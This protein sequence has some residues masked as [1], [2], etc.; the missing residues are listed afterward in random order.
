M[1]LEDRIEQLRQMREAEP[2]AAV[3]AALRKALKDRSNLIVTEAAKAVG[4]LRR[5]AL[6]E[7]LLSAFDRLFENPVKTDPKCWGKTAIVK[8]LTS[9]DYSESPPFLRGARHVQMEPV[10]GGQEDAAMHLRANSV[11]ALVACTDLTRPE[12]LRHLV[13]AL[14][15][16]LDTVRVEAV[17]ALQQ[18]NGEESCLALRVKAHAGDRRPVVLGQVFDSILQLE[19]ELAVPFIAGFMNSSNDETRDEA[20]LALGGSRLPSAV[21]ALIETWDHSRLGEFGPVVLRALSSSRDET[22]FAFLLN[23]VKGGS[24]RDSAAALDALQLHK[25]FPEI[26]ERI[27]DAVRRTSSASPD[28]SPRL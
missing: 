20:A 21:K 5:T 2:G 10:W 9:M 1:K 16:D 11:L 17:R 14:A 6:L 23:L 8:A 18:M 19:G 22:A 24:T 4:H 28:N 27:N 13:D 15:D 12:I 25:D 3:D 26:Q 7:D